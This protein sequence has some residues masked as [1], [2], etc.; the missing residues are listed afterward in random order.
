[1]A[2]S[3]WELGPVE[4]LVDLVVCVTEARGGNLDQDLVTLRL[5]GWDL[6]EL[7]V[8]VV[9]CLMSVEQELEVIRPKSSH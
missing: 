6:L 9:L 7:V 3:E 2:A 1:M 8:F 4:A 5:R